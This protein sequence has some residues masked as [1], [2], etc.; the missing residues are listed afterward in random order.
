M[1]TEVSAEVALG[2]CVCMYSS[3]TNK[4]FGAYHSALVCIFCTN[5]LVLLLGEHM[6]HCSGMMQ[7]LT[8]LGH[9]LLR[10]ALWRQDLQSVVHML[11]PCM[12]WTAEHTEDVVVNLLRINY[13]LL[14]VTCLKQ[15][16]Q[17]GHCTDSKIGQQICSSH[18][19]HSV[20]SRSTRLPQCSP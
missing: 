7:W 10:A 13:H 1:P 3:P 5:V 18:R 12:Q 15:N 4:C 6:Q 11:L 9:K 19:F 16:L 17:E 8:H 14:L 20:T 2:L